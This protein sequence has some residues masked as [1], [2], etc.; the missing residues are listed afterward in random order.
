MPDSACV[1]IKS[2]NLDY[3]GAGP[4]VRNDE[5]GAS[6]NPAGGQTDIAY[7][8][9][10]EP[11]GWNDQ[12]TRPL[13]AYLPGQEP[14]GWNDQLFKPMNCVGP[15]DPDPWAD[16]PQW[17]MRPMNCV[18][19]GEADPYANWD[20]LQPRPMGAG[21]GE[22]PAAIAA[23]APAKAYLP[24]CEPPGWNDG[25]WQ[26]TGA[27]PSACA[28]VPPGGWGR[29]P[30]L[31]PMAAL[32]AKNEQ[33]MPAV[34]PG[35]VVSDWD[36][37]RMRRDHDR[38]RQLGGMMD[39]NGQGPVGSRTGSGGDSVAPIYTGGGDYSGM[40]GGLKGPWVDPFSGAADSIWGAMNPIFDQN[41]NW[42]TDFDMT[43]NAGSAQVS[44]RK[45][46]PLSLRQAGLSRPPG[47]Y[48]LAEELAD[49]FGRIW[50]DPLGILAAVVVATAIVVSAFFTGGL[51]LYVF[52]GA[53][54]M[55]MIADYAVGF[56]DQMYAGGAGGY[57]LE[58]TIGA[59]GV[60]DLIARSIYQILGAVSELAIVAGAWRFA[61]SEATW[62][63]ENIANGFKYVAGRRG[64]K[65]IE[66]NYRELYD[67]LERFSAR[68]SNDFNIFR[69]DAYWRHVN[70]HWGY[71]P[72]GNYGGIFGRIGGRY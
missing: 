39:S 10:T 9:G 22:A 48:T 15:N 67:V 25:R 57:W 8:P 69:G 4:H 36:R 65:Y 30:P 52:A 33:L 71:R 3:V 26:L 12:L 64:V 46:K 6:L 53:A 58:N 11:P 31:E 68:D 42:L 49:S 55:S 41:G 32:P 29:V 7:L 50:D 56:A 19:P 45:M 40:T 61:A 5:L 14:P 43:G 18:G 17:G 28:A 2:P 35:Q 21:T 62:A 72:S 13:I 23:P 63:E 38:Q 60:R 37:H 66:A 1:P 44:Q 24:G 70:I 16:M 27:S 20:P 54:F 47:Q 59:G 34:A 51:S